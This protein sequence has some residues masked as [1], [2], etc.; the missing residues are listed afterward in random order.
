LELQL[1]FRDLELFFR[2]QGYLT[3]TGSAGYIPFHEDEDTTAIR[4]YLGDV[5][6]ESALIVE[7]K[8]LVF[9]KKSNPD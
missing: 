5:L 4:Q 1:I 2:V 6:G 8:P 7:T 3:G 9:A